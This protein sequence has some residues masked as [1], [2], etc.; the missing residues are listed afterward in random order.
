[1]ICTPSKNFRRHRYRGPI[2]RLPPIGVA[3]TKGP[4]MRPA[5]RWIALLLTKSKLTCPSEP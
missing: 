5:L 1:M 4:D 3:D 2:F